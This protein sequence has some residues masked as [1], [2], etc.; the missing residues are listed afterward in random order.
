MWVH[1]VSLLTPPKLCP[2]V[3]HMVARFVVSADPQGVLRTRVETHGDVQFVGQ[4]NDAFSI[5]L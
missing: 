2:L 4:K 5:S 3:R 1:F